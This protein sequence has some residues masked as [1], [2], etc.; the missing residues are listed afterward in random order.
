MIANEPT[1]ATPSPSR[2]SRSN[3]SR[4]TIAGVSGTWA[5][6]SDSASRRLDIQPIPEYSA[7]SRPTKPTA[8]RWS[9]AWSMIGLI[10]PARFAGTFSVIAWRSSSSSDGLKNSTYPATAKAIISSG[11]R[12]S[13]LKKVI[14][15][16]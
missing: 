7:A 9:I 2:A 4:L 6:C 16:A 11:T 3:S 15:A 1:S 12:E 8:P 10:V 5:H 13:T 14:A